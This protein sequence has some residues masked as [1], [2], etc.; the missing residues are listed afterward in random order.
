VEAL[1]HLLWVRLFWREDDVA[2]VGVDAGWNH[3]TLI[4]QQAVGSG[5]SAMESA[6]L[7][8]RLTVLLP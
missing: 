8:L 2:D 1:V 4:E 7:L 5:G 3:E 6:P